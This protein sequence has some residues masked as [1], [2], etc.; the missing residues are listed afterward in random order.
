MNPLNDYNAIASSLGYLYQFRYALY[1]AIKNEPDY[2]SVETADDIFFEN[3]EEEGLIQVK[4]S[5]NP[6]KLTLS[7]PQIW[8]TLRI[9][10]DYLKKN[11]EMK[12]SFFLVTSDDLASLDLAELISS[13]KKYD[14]EKGVSIIKA[15]ANASENKSLKVCYETIL[16]ESDDFLFRLLSRIELSGGSP[17]FPDVEKQIKNRLEYVVAPER[18]DLMFGHLEGWWIGFIIKAMR[19]GECLIDLQS[20]KSAIR[21]ISD[22]Y[23]EGSL[24]TLFEE[25]FPDK[26]QSYNFLNSIFVRQLK[27]INLGSNRVQRAINDYYRAFNE[28]VSWVKN[29]FL[30]D[31]DLGAYDRDLIEEWGHYKEICEEDVGGEVTE[32][33]LIECGKKIYNHFMSDFSGGNIKNVNRG[34]VVKGSLHIL[35]DKNPPS[36]YW[37]PKFIDRLSEVLK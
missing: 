20:L 25:V 29:G 37:H 2:I 8:K 14:I 6:G 30:I 5:E 18:V 31:Y 21:Q 35:A 12:G 28:R 32:E 34:Y 11:P 23:K 27:E 3:G 10:V 4:Q 19:K 22:S 7:S 17:S 15:F 16:A 26:D 9:W 36:V 33:K 1:V 13:G 24:P